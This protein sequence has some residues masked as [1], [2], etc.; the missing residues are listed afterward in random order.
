MHLIESKRKEMN[1]MFIKFFQTMQR[2]KKK[3]SFQHHY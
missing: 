3:E 1:R 2:K